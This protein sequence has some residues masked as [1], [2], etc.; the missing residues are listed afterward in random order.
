MENLMTCPRC[1]FNVD[2]SYFGLNR[3]QKPYKTCDN[4]SNKKRT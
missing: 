4:C 1:K 2:V 3:T